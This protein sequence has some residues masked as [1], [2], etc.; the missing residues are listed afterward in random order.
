MML[1]LPSWPGVVDAA[2]SR[3]H[4]TAVGSTLTLA[5]AWPTT[6]LPSLACH[7]GPAKCVTM[8]SP[9]SSKRSRGVR[10]SSSRCR[11]TSRS[12]RRPRGRSGTPCCRRVPGS[13][14][15]RT[16]RAVRPGPPARGTHGLRAKRQGGAASVRARVHVPGCAQ[17]PDQKAKAAASA[18][19]PSRWPSAHREEEGDLTE[20][21]ARAES[22]GCLPTVGQ[23]IGAA[24]FDEIDGGSVVVERD[25][26]GARVDLDLLT[27]AASSSSSAAGRSATSGTAAIRLLSTIADRATGS[28][29]LRLTARVGHRGDGRLVV[30]DS[31]RWSGRRPRRRSMDRPEHPR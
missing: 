16:A 14:P 17:S 22:S 15:G 24:L 11:R 5:S 8:S 12:G 2:D 25:D 30:A 6:M 27:A 4:G 7:D 28:N 1:V 20:R 10:R 3:T 13:G 9:W 18:C 26:L 23:N 29:R 21:V 19:A 31:I